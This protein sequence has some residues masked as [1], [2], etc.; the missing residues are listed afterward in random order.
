MYGIRKYP[1]QHLLWLNNAMHVVQFST[2][3]PGN[4]TKGNLLNYIPTIA[5]QINI[6]QEI[7]TSKYNGLTLI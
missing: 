6:V 3:T 4:P 7:I 5:I 2:I 1:F